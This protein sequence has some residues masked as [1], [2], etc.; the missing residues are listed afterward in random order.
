MLRSPLG[1]A[2]CRA[3]RAR[4]GSRAGQFGRDRRRD[5]AA[6]LDQAAARNRRVAGGR[7]GR[8]DGS[9]ASLRK[10]LCRARDPHRADSA[11]ARRSGRPRTLSE[12]ALHAADAAASWR[13]CRSSTRTTPSSPTKSSSATTTRSVR[14][15]ANLIEG[16]A[17]DDPHRSARP[18]HRR[19][20]QGS[21]RHARSAGRCRCAGTRSNGGRCRFEPGPWRH[22]DQDSR[23]QTRG[24]QRREYGDRERA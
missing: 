3:A 14:L 13:A 24:A 11:D 1:R 23:G 12:R 10:Q 19:S 16:D 8:S 17:L 6:G 20:A 18:L 9:R 4:Q 5:A 15:V 21:E 7:G 22:A 2:D